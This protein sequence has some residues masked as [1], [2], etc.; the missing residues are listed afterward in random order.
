MWWLI[1]DDCII[2]PHFLL[3][4]I[5]FRN[6]VYSHVVV[7]ICG[8]VNVCYMCV[9]ECIRVGINVSVEVFSYLFVSI[10]IYVFKSVL[11]KCVFMH[12]G[13]CMFMGFD[14]CF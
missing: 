13:K 14:V 7:S 11:S 1:I 9:S 2:I 12:V 4:R 10:S 8:Y 6:F 3:D 5:F